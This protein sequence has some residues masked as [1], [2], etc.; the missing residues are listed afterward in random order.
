MIY[1]VEP[2]Q[3][4]T[5][6]LPSINMALLQVRHIQARINGRLHRA[7]TQQAVLDSLLSGPIPARV[8]RWIE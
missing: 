8:T 7:E 1:Q 2:V 6:A 4:R 5:E 3:T